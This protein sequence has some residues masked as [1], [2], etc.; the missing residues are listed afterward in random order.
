M[1]SQ[2]AHD[3]GEDALM[4]RIRPEHVLEP[5]ARQVER[6]H[7][8][9][10]GVVDEAKT[11]EVGSVSGSELGD[12][13]ASSPSKVAP[14]CCFR[15]SITPANVLHSATTLIS[16]NFLHRNQAAL[17]SLAQ[18][19]WRRECGYLVSY[20]SAASGNFQRQKWGRTTPAQPSRR[21]AALFT[22]AGPS[23]DRPP[24]LAHPTYVPPLVEVWSAA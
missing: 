24:S 5:V 17:T 9:V 1:G 6:R 16:Y 10:G 2:H 4:A 15:R 19:S 3:L 13:L 11:I 18:L 20:G 21:L 14:H 12:D 7:G 22:S 23:L 8:C